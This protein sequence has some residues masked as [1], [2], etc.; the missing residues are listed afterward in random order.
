MS[1]NILVVLVLMVASFATGFVT[2]KYPGEARGAA[3]NVLQYLKSPKCPANYICVEAPP[4]V[5]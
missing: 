4:Q 2:A 1:I 3:Y 5:E